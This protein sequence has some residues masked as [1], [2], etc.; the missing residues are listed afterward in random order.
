MA[1]PLGTRLRPAKHRWPLRRSQ[2]KHIASTGPRGRPTVDM[3]GSTTV[4]RD[5]VGFI[6]DVKTAVAAYFVERDLSQNADL[7]MVI[8]TAIILAVT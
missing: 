4:E 8:K 1:E 5:A 2:C 3:S 7:G 6:A